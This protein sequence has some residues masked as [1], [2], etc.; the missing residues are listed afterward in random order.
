MP[1]LKPLPLVPTV[2]QGWTEVKHNGDE[3]DCGTT[4]IKKKYYKSC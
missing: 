3:I 2:A 4:T 1:D